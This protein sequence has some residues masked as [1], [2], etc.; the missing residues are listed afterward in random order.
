MGN[1][2][3]LLPAVCLLGMLI[4]LDFAARFRS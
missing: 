1:A 2:A 3:A 4:T